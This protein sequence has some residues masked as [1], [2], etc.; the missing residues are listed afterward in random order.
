MPTNYI[1]KMHALFTSHRFASAD[2]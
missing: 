2:E 1:L